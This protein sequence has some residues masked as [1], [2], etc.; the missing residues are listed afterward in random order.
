MSHK[1]RLGPI[2]IFLTIIAIVMATLAVL[3]TATTN[4]D[5]VMAERFAEVTKTR[6][7]LEAEGEKFIREF[8]EQAGSGKIDAKKLGAKKSGAAYIKTIKNNGY[9]LKAGVT[10]AGNKDGYKITEWKLE[11]EWNADDPYS[12]VWKGE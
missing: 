5:K 9:I 6:Y 8:D 4:A 1:I 10:S 3:T 7:A 12:N 2:A 11:K